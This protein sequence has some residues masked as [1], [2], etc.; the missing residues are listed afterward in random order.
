MRYTYR[1]C[2][3]EDQPMDQSVQRAWSNYE[4]KN[5]IANSEYAR[6]GHLIDRRYGDG[7]VTVAPIGVTTLRP[8]SPVRPVL[9]Q[10]SSRGWSA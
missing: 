1:G 7:P 5:R 10:L 9:G 6:I 3:P 8:H 4:L 2:E